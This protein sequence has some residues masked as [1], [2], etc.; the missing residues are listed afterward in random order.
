MLI[1]VQIRDPAG[2]VLWQAVAPVTAGLATLA[3][4]AG[5]AKL[6]ALVAGNYVKALEDQ[7]PCEILVT[8]L[9]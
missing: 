1:S 4:P 7:M 9:P 3:T 2:A 8:V 5:L 6:C